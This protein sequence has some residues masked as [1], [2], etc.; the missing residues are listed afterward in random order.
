MECDNVCASKARGG[1]KKRGENNGRERER[2]KQGEAAAAKQHRGLSR[3]EN[4]ARGIRRRQPA[5]SVYLT[6]GM[7]A[8]LARMWR[9]HIVRS[10]R[11]EKGAR[12][13]H[14]VCA[15]RFHLV[16]IFLGREMDAF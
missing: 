14:A 8:R 16:G 3:K 15:A 2:E 7:T 6:L 11:F 5:A 12:V 1:K 4:A 13:S 9:Q 10:P